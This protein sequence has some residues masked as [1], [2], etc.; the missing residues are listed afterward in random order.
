[1]CSD[2]MRCP[3]CENG[4]LTSQIGKNP[5]SYKGKTTEL[6]LHFSICEFCGSEQS[7]AI[8]VRDNKRAMLAFKKR[9]DGL[10]SGAE[11]R[12]LRMKLN[13]SQATKLSK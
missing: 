13:L 9:V 2:K 11:V 12:A 6:D 10:L 7:D 5:V 1:M 4:N 8:Q 3:I